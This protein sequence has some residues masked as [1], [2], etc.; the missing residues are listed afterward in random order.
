ME[1]A[2]VIA[3]AAVAAAA[4]LAAHGSD[5]AKAK[6]FG[7]QQDHALPRDGALLRKQRMRGGEDLEPVRNVTARDAEHQ[8]GLGGRA[9]AGGRG[10]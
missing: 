3:S 6:Q 1:M 5:D 2:V 7:R 4:A 9:V 10:G 8:D